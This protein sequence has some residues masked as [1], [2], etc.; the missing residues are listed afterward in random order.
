MFI[1]PMRDSSHFFLDKP[2]TAVQYCLFPLLNKVFKPLA[3]KVSAKPYAGSLA[4]LSSVNSSLMGK[5]VIKMGMGLKEESTQSL[6]D[7]G[8]EPLLITVM[9]VSELSLE[10]KAWLAPL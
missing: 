10:F 4:R 7:F 2:S 5:G 9:E 1:S 6:R 3:S 8:L